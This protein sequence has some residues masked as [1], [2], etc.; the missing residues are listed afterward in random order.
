M[1]R[2][3]AAAVNPVDAKTRSGAVP[4]LVVKLPRILGSD[5][6]GVV[7][8]ADDDSRG[9][10]KKGDR[11]FACTG[12]HLFTSAYGT[13]AE[14]VAAPERCFARVP[15]RLSLVDA[16]AVPLAASTAWQA[17]AP[18]MPLAGKSV[19]VHA[20]AGGVG[21]FAV[22]IAKA[23]GAARVV[24]TCG[25]AN[26]GLVKGLGA[27]QVVDYTKERFE[28]AAPGPYD[29]IVD[30]IGGEYEA[31]GLKLLRKRGGGGGSSGGGSG[32]GGSDGGDPRGGHYVH[33][34]THGWN[35]R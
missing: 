14:L 31:R 13:Y 26:V 17:L 18:R 29:V 22:Q 16:A 35:A 23:Q 3:A 33:L 20:G 19:L 5:V 21:S 12:Q 25:P 4:R 11:V 10:F 7:V 2:V 8:E 24:A 32:G 9:G 6:A 27:T 15:D 1:V 34:L 30:T 28:E